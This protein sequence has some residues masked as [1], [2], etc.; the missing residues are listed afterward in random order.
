MRSDIFYE[1]HFFFFSGYDLSRNLTGI[2]K[3]SNRKDR[4]TGYSHTL[5]ESQDSGLG[6]FHRLTCDR[7]TFPKVPRG[8]ACGLGGGPSSDWTVP[9]SVVAKR[10]VLNLLEN[11]REPQVGEGAGLVGGP[12]WHTRWLL[13]NV[14]LRQR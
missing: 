12:A 4:S 5:N 7:T 3:S 10:V 13:G 8:Y 1:F 2:W 14:V 9:S 11:V 6:F